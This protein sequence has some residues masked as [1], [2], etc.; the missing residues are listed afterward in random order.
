MK[1]KIL[2]LI[3]DELD[4]AVKCES[5]NIKLPPDAVIASLI[6][7]KSYIERIL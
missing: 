4:W 3:E 5:N 7:I 6:R 2:K 1:N